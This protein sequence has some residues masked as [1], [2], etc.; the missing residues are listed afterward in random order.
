MT[1][2]RSDDRPSVDPPTPGSPASV[3]SQSTPDQAPAGQM[4][5]FGPDDPSVPWPEL[6]GALIVEFPSVAGPETAALARAAGPG[7]R[8]IALAPNPRSLEAIDPD[9]LDEAAIERAPDAAPIDYRRG[10]PEAPGLDRPE[11]GAIDVLVV[12]R[13]LAR[14][15]DPLNE[16]RTLVDLVRPG[17][18]VVLIDE[19]RGSVRMHPPCPRFERAWRE[20]WRDGDAAGQ[21]RTIGRRLPELLHRSGCRPTA[22]RDLPMGRGTG[23][24][25][26]ADLVETLIA[27][28]L[29]TTEAPEAAVPRPRS[30]DDDGDDS[31]VAAADA[32][33][34]WATQPH[35]AIWITDAWASG[36]RERP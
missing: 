29:G 16:L 23:D 36:V 25:T 22:S 15:T 6:A 10:T 32:L 28:M 2:P 18:H 5:P 20:A 19:D 3:V 31:R 8:V 33:R 21:D 27:R 26:F 30:L 17:G 1:S 4:P 24:A 7:G 12:R 9:R 13:H 11:R 35:A 34:T 14:V